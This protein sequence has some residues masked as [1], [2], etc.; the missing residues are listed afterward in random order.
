MTTK[1]SGKTPSRR[2]GPGELRRQVAQLL[3]NDPSRHWRPADMAKALGGRSSGAVGNALE[4]LVH[5][6]HAHRMGD[7][8]RAYAASSTTA[9]AAKPSPRAAAHH[10]RPASPAPAA[11]PTQA[12]SSGG[13]R[14]V[15]GPVR[16]P[17]GQTYH[18]RVLADLPDVTVLRRLRNANNPRPALRAARDREDEPGRGRLSRPDHRGRRRRHHGRR[19]RGRICSA[20]PRA[21]TSSVGTTPAY[22]APYCRT[23]SPLDFHSR[24]MW[25]PT[26]IWLA[27]SRSTPGQSESLGTLP[28]ARQRAR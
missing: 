4:A 25:K 17:N 16:R 8:P 14:P 6:G 18:P 27:P 11:Q 26:M 5:A 12:T 28:P 7:N 22:T 19:L 2:L 10:T 24:C 9:E 21:S 20:P 23:L 15:N 13:N 1:P 3:A